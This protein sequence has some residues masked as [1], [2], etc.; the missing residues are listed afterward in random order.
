MRKRF[1]FALFLTLV[2][3]IFCL[4]LWTEYDYLSF[5]RTLFNKGVQIDLLYKGNITRA[6]PFRLKISP[7]PLNNISC[8]YGSDNLQRAVIKLRAKG[9]WQKLN[10]QLEALQD[11]EITM[12]FRG[13]DVHDEHDRIYSILTDWRNL[14]VN[15][16]I[17]FSGCRNFTY[18]ECYVKQ[19]TV[20]KHDVLKIEAEFRRHHFSIHDFTFLKAGNLWYLIT[21]NLLFFL[22]IWRLLSVST[23]HRGRIDRSDVFL[24][25]T[26]FLCTLIPMIYISDEVKNVRENRM[27][28]VKPTLKQILRGG[29]GGGY[30]E[31]FNDHVGGRTALIKLRDIIRNMLSHVI[32]TQKAIY[33][34]E[35]GWSFVLPLESRIDG[36][37]AFINSVVQSLVQLNQFCQQNQIKLYVMDVPRKENVYKELLSDEYGFDEKTFT[38]TSQVQETIRNETRKHL[39][40]WIYPYEALR[41]ASKRDFVYFKWTHHWTDWGAFVGYQELMKEIRKDFPDIPVASLNDFRKS[42]NCF[43]RDDFHE[44]YF[45]GRYLWINYNYGD[46]DDAPRERTQYNYYDHKRGDIVTYKVG[47]FTKDFSYPRGKHKI[48]LIG[49]SQN[50]NL[51]HFLPYSAALTK[52]IRLNMGQVKG[53]ETWKILKLYK[54]DILAFKPEILV[55]SIPSEDI[56]QIR[57]F[58]STK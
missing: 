20:K 43:I 39:I 25:V 47:K 37:P 14:K 10:L 50:E 1:F 19:I 21:G 29:T 16:H 34:K 8:F 45:L 52:Y 30:E 55:L 12:V 40:P 6:E 13:P 42:T 4:P 31:W 46:G 33:L 56:P 18:L 24:L 48:M 38:R 27:L 36:S 54:K 26:F 2:A 7:E 11:G 9:K 57:E 35:K 3:D 22:L 58:S 15:D 51:C 28:A 5:I 53:T 44:D 41:N 23:I 32:S 49:T 17:L